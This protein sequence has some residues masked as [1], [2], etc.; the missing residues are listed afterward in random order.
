MS[1][2][3]FLLLLLA[4]FPAAG[5]QPQKEQEPP[6]EDESLSTKKEYAFNP[7]QASKEVQIG[8]FYLKKGK[9]RAAAKRFDEATHWNPGLGEAWLRLAE[10]RE[11]LKDPKGAHG[12]YA[13]YLEL[14][15]DAKNA[16]QIRK[17]LGKSK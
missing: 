5:Q 11:K 14:E 1:R 4:V 12:A 9:L 3:A 13:R 8:I 2:Q 16:A 7:L 6:E 15:P 10:T 17:K